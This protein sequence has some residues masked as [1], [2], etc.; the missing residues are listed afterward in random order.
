MSYKFR[1]Y[2]QDQMYPMGDAPTN[3][4]RPRRP[5]TSPSWRAPN[6]AWPSPWAVARLRRYATRNDTSYLVVG[7][8]LA[9]AYHSR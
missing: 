2:A 5:F 1:P 4:E 8:Q 3:S 9:R 6:G 7:K